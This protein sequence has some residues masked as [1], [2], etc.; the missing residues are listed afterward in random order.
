MIHLGKLKSWRRLLLL[1]TTLC[2]GLPVFSQPESN[3]QVIVGIAAGTQTTIW[4]TVQKVALEKYGLKV[5]LVPLSEYDNLDKA[6]NNGDLDANAFQHGLYL[7]EEIKLHHYRLQPVA[8]TFGHPIGLYSISVRN[9]KNF[10]T[11]DTIGIA[12]DP[13]ET[14]RALHLLQQAGLI[15]LES[16]NVSQDMTLIDVKS[17]PEKLKIVMMD[18]ALLANALQEGKLTAVVLNNNYANGAGFKLKDA[19]VIENKRNV[20]PYVDLIVARVNNSNTKKIQELVAAYQS[21]E[22]KA[23]AQKVYGK[24]TVTGW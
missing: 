2:C 4:Q 21:P 14:A 19:L 13:I 3:N 11:G 1:M 9:I 10:K 5:V 15:T 23:E 18:P 6:L 24:G 8:K 12:Q 20:M 22:V 16:S 7:K 17:N